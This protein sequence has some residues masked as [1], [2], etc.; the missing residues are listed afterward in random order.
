MLSLNL[1]FE[2]SSLHLVIV[3]WLLNLRDSAS[4]SETKETCKELGTKHQ[5]QSSVFQMHQF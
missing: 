5:V 4:W 1:N 2:L 3:L